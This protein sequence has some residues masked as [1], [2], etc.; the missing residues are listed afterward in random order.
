[1][2][3]R[4][5][6]RAPNADYLGLEASPEAIAAVANKVEEPGFD[7]KFV[8]HHIVVGDGARSAP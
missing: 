8:N 7:G 3:V 4:L 5:S 2:T 6:T 1:M